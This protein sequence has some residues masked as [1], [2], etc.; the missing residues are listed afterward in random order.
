[1]KKQYL[2][3]GAEAV[4]VARKAFEVE[5]EKK[6]RPK[7]TFSLHDDPAETPRKFCLKCARTIVNGQAH[8][9]EPKET[10]S[11]LSAARTFPVDDE[12]AAVS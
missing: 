11:A 4:N 6:K 1:M 5:E 7:M 3:F 10:K 9:C 12:I 2:T 8:V